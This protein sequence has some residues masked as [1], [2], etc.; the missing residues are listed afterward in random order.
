VDTFLQ[1][2]RYAVRWLG[3]S[4]GF[5]L[6]AVLCL[7]IGIGVNTTIFSCVYGGLMR[8]YDFKAPDRLVVLDD[9]RPKEPDDNYSISYLNALD[10]KQH[11]TSY[12][13]M[14][15]STGRSMT[16]TDGDEPQRYF[17]ERVSWNLFSLLGKA[18]ILG[19]DFRAEDDQPGAPL[20]AILSH[21]LW[22]QRYHADPAIMN[23]T[24]SLNDEPCTVIGVMP[25]RFQFSDNTKLWIPIAGSGLRTARTDRLY[26]VWAR[27]K[28]SVTVARA[29]AEAT[30]FAKT[31]AEEY[32]AANQSYTSK[33]RSL[34]DAFRPE[35]I[36][37]ILL[38][39]YGAV[40]CVLLIACANVANLLLARASTRAREIAIRSAIGAG[41]G[42]IVRQL[43]T[44]SVLLGLL[45][46]TLGVLVAYW[47]LDLLTAAI[48]R[49][50]PLPYYV[51][52]Q[53]DPPTLGYALLVSVFTGVLFG[54][55]PALEA[56][57]TNLTESLKEGS[58][59]TGTGARRGRLRSALV[60]TE[61]A[62]ALV[63]L[64]GAALFVRSF[65]KLQGAR[66]GFET[67]QLMTMRVYMTQQH[68]PTDRARLQRVQDLVR[69]IEG[70]PGV[71]SAAAS[72]TILIGGGGSLDAAIVEGKTFPSGEEPQVF[73]TG[74]TPH[75]FKTYGIPIVR[76][77]DFTD[78]EG[79]DST[80]V[81]VI[82][83]AFA[84]KL[85]GDADPLG[86]HFRFASDSSG[87][88]LTVIGVCKD[89]TVRDI[90]R[91]K[92]LVAAFVPYLYLSTPNTGITVRVT[93]DPAGITNAG[94]RA[95]HEADPGMPVFD[96]YTM[97]SVRQQ[98]FWD[99]GLFGRMF[100]IFG[101]IALVLA[102][103]GVYGVISYSVS[104]RTHEIGVR[105]ALGASN[106]DVLRLVVGQGV[107]LALIGVGI[108][109]VAALGVTQIIRSQLWVSPTDPTSFVGIA[110]IL[111]AVACLASWVPARRALRVEPMVALREE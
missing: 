77:R 39:M 37:L 31:L 68:Y 2:L 99:K 41:R 86:Q 104:Q 102:S 81:A 47:G 44:E 67:G 79:N 92:E 54:L 61:V 8:P 28:P 94:R 40:G 42:R 26:T 111:T 98:S 88:W 60:V 49:N 10:W 108:G 65:L 70:L 82:N 53:I 33:V 22:Q 16:L 55:A 9:R 27:L 76:G 80:A 59:G 19:R 75:W 6:L 90:D 96:P 107:R 73:Y 97:E 103:I 84:K 89:H 71:E 21:E 100:T 24:I 5:T 52:W 83:G 20:V 13:D 7:G 57:R 66:V 72:N 74:V 18:P 48:P 43:L 14:A 109:L 3:K 64:V 93:R 106:S 63:L 45:G 95:I 56:A 78:S 110:A 85:W 91:R 12:E 11:A 69:R 87:R 25:P 101:V 58:R 38:T 23:R 51:Y 46:G 35:D 62:L 17:G 15:L 30:Q 34:A 50:D 4:P 29:Q 1:D 36:R 32:P 105:R